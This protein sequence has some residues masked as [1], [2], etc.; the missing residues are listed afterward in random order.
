MLKPS[1]MIYDSTKAIPLSAISQ[2]EDFFGDSDS[3]TT[4]KEQDAYTKVSW[5]RRC[6]DLRA[7]ALSS[8]P[9][10]VYRGEAGGD[11][12]EWEY[13]DQLP[14]LLWQ[15]SAALQIYGR[16]YWMRQRN[17]YGVDKGFRWLLP[18][19][20]VPKFDREK[21]LVGFDRE[22]KG[23]RYPLEVDDLV[24]FWVPPT[25]A[26][27]GPG[28]GWVTTALPAAEIIYSADSLITQ[29]FANGAFPSGILS[30][31]GQ[32]SVKALDELQAWFKRRLG[33][34]VK[35]AGKIAAVAAEITFERV[36]MGLDELA[37]EQVVDM[38]RQQI[39]TAAGVP[40]TMLEDA[41]NYA[42]AQEHHKSLYSETVVP[43]AVL[44]EG[45]LNAQVF[46][47]QGQ[48][49]NMDW[50][51]LDV[52]Q[53]DEA[54]RSE[55]LARLTQAGLPVEFAME[56]LGFDLPNEMTYQQLTD[57]LKERKEENT[58]PQLQP[59]VTLPESAPT[60]PN[61]VPPVSEQPVTRA[62]S[63]DLDRWR[64]KSLSSLKAGN[65][66]DVP[67]VSEVIPD[68]TAAVLHE[69]LASAE[70]ADA[71]RAAFEPPF[72]CVAHEHG[73]AK[74][75]PY[76]VIEGEP[77]PP[78]DE[79]IISDDDVKRAFARWN[80]IMPSDVTDLLDAGVEA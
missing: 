40:Q 52:F 80:A 35:N 11:E 1:I 37:L 29:T 76:L 59:G 44:I 39:A 58:P 16:A 25:G 74:A 24:Y 38:A 26:E 64:R 19:S 36:S 60:M 23:V 20:I 55:S 8:I 62:V 67:F 42:T 48:T 33:G 51:S 54:S 46:E 34:G 45:A 9:C 28:H 27:L 32:P 77:L 79:V 75:E 7:N 53:V 21:G 31:K 73:D 14:A 41:A 10:A 12:I 56:L 63:D 78:M 61:T 66:A 50:Q 47:P 6:V 71:V 15:T 72:C 69:R 49:F 57:M 18:T 3:S 13:A 4:L 2:W 68:A 65:V 22:V 5:V 70:D 43:E 17:R 30:V